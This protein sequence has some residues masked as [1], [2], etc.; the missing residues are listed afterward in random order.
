MANRKRSPKERFLEKIRKTKSKPGCWLWTASKFSNGYGQF[1]DGKRKI[2]AHRFSYKVTCGKIPA[3][4]LVCHTCD[5]PSCVNPNHL[6]LGTH[7]ENFADMDKKGRRRCADS[8]GVKNGRA[9]LTE[10]QVVSL[11][12]KYRGILEIRRRQRIEN[13]TLKDLAVEYGI[14]ESQALRV[15]K[16][17]SWQNTKGK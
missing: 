9:V 17:D 2:G 15:V 4:L 5:K 10:K 11:R 14:S 1:F 13:R 3:K 16:G 7:V 6:F 12:E 8:S